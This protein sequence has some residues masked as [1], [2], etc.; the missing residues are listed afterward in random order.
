MN[1][2]VPFPIPWNTFPADAPNGTYNMNRHISCKNPAIN[3]ASCAL[4]SEYE[5][6]NAICVAKMYRIAHTII[7]DINPTF[8]E[9]LV[10]ILRFSYFLEPNATPATDIAPVPTPIAGNI[11]M[12]MILHPAVYT[13]TATG[14]D[15]TVNMKLTTTANAAIINCSRL[16]GIPTTRISLYIVK[17]FLKSFMSYAR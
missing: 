16:A 3:G 4:D 2:V 10:V 1:D 15:T 14:P 5:N 17:L 8:T 6:I 11:P 9:Y 13:A 12:D 7:D